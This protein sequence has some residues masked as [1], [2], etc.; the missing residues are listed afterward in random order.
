MPRTEKEILNDFRIIECNMSPENL[1]CDG[2]ASQAQVNKKLKELNAWK[3]KLIK[4]LGRTP[5]DTEIYGIH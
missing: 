5:T 4:E 1:H 2:E 3:T